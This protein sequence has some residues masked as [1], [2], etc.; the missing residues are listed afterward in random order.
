VGHGFPSRGSPK[1]LLERSP[2]PLEWRVSG[3]GAE[4]LG[5][6]PHVGCVDPSRPAS[7]RGCGCRSQAARRVRLE[8]RRDRPGHAR[9]RPG[10][11]ADHGP[12][13][14]G[15]PR[16]SRI[17]R[18]GPGSVMNAISRMSPP[19]AWALDRKLL[20]MTAGRGIAPLADVPDGECRHG[21]PELVI[22]GKHGG[23]VRCIVKRG[24]RR[25]SATGSNILPRAFAGRRAPSST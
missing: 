24:I 8:R 5:V 15:S 18:I 20:P 3:V 7:L 13:R 2:P 12:V 11:W 1:P 25:S 21:P 14:A 19:T 4:F 9:A 16:W 6:R 10:W 17:F 23:V 22:R